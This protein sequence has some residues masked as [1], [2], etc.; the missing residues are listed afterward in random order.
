MSRTPESK[1]ITST[2]MKENNW[3]KKVG[4]PFDN[5]LAQPCNASFPQGCNASTPYPNQ[6]TTK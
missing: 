1:I 3:R 4:T 2:A 6:C 5:Q